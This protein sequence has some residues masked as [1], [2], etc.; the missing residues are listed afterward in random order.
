MRLFQ[1]VS[2][3]A[4][5]LVLTAAPLLAQDDAD[6]AWLLS[7]INCLRQSVGVPPLMLNAALI[8]SANRQS[9]NLSNDNL[10]NYHVGLDG[11]TPTTR[12]QGA[13]FTGSVGENVA[14]GRAVSDAFTW[15]MHSPIH[16]E[17]MTNAHW[18]EIG[19]GVGHGPYGTWYTLD[20]GAMTWQVTGIV[21][22]LPCGTFDTP[23]PNPDEASQSGATNT[24]TLNTPLPPTPLVPGFDEHGYI[25]HAIQSG[26]TPGII[27][28]KY[29]YTWDDLPALMALN[30]MTEAEARRLNVGDIFLIPPREGLTTP[31]LI[32]DQASD[33]ILVV[34]DTPAPNQPTATLSS[35]PL[36][37]LTPTAT[38]PLAP[39]VTVIVPS[40][41]SLLT[42]TASPEPLVLPA[43]FS[44]TVTPIP[45]SEL[46]VPPAAFVASPV[47][48][49]MPT[50]QAP[51]PVPDAASNDRLPLLFGLVIGLQII[52]AGLL[53]ANLYRRRTRAV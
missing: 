23:V 46:L 24:I 50:L 19:I 39:T 20:F 40:T 3:L 12:A 18:K 1:R 25:Q 26:E 32:V 43:E 42:G 49:Q 4:L 53:A 31:T 15:W 11:S 28:L 35:T 16:Y 33:I 30:H 29:G 2:F 36:P 34:S 14:S 38:I 9:H 51:V 10:T 13:G 45:S 21:S 47:P 6:S 17:N 5:L 52:I 44:A 22:A 37:S 7:Q 8:V 27:I 48:T 41:Q